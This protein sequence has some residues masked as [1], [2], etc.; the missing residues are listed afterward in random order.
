M[1]MKRTAIA[2]FVALA[3]LFSFQ[4]SNAASP[5]VSTSP[6]FS[7]DF[8]D[9]SKVS[10]TTWTDQVAGLS[11]AAVGTQFSSEFGGIETF[12][13]NTSYLSFGKPAIGSAINPSGDM[14]GEVW[15]KF[16]AF[17]TNWNVFLTKWFDDL[18]GSGPTNDYHLAVYTDGTSPRQLNLYT[19]N[20][21]DLRGSTTI[22]L[23]QW[24]HFVFTIDNTSATK[25]IA[26]YVNGNLDATYTSSSSV[27][28][29]NTNNMFFI[30]DA[31]NLTGPNAMISKVRIYNKALTAPEVASNYA[32]DLTQFTPIANITLTAGNGV[33]RTP[34]NI[35]ATSTKP[36]I[37]KFY[38]NNKLISGCGKMQIAT[39]ITCSWRPA[40]RGNMTVKVVVVPSDVAIASKTAQANLFIA[41]RILKR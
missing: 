35:T 33:F 38:V 24:Y 30:G 20:K 40:T 15:I 22:V 8:S 37:A 16:L 23:N 34:Q 19:T 13:S 12:T 21:Y 27:R 11:A 7:L 2:A 3:V 32:I 17:N 9:S 31:R 1:I 10:G 36:G 28:T 4:Q 14:S 41:N 18:A 26:L 25:K 29:A 39:S 5:A 6:T